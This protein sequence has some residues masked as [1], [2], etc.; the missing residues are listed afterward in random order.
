MKLSVVMIVRN[1]EACLERCL[2]SVHGA[3]ELIICDTG[4]SDDTV[5]L[6]RFFTPHVFTDFPWCDD[7]SA[8]RN[9]ALEKATGDWV[10]SMDADHV[11]LTPMREVRQQA[12]IAAGGGHRVAAIHSTSSL[13]HV[14]FERAADIRWI[15]RVHEV[16]SRPATFQSTVCE[17]VGYSAAHALAPDRNL[18]ILLASDPSSARTRFYLGREYLDRGRWKEAEIALRSY[19]EIASWRPEIADAWLCLARSLWHQRRGDEARSACALA[20]A[21]NPDFRAAILCMAEMSDARHA[22][23][24]KTLAATATDSGVLFYTSARFGQS[25]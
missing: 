25:A 8:A 9:H 15:G 24:W 14:L 13:R 17:Q 20:I 2:R 11:L 19:L 12:E 7:F 4:S 10:L 5:A 21:L 3:D 22:A 1:E 18:R 6:A 23:R 16:L